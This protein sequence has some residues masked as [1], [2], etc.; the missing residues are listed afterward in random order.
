VPHYPQVNRL[1]GTFDAPT[2][3]AAVYNSRRGGREVETEGVMSGHN[4][5]STIKH[6]KGKADA[7]RGKIFTK[8]I[9]ELTTAAKEGGGDPDGNPRLRSAIAAAKAANMPGDTLKKAIQRGTGELPGVAYEEVM[10]EG[11]GPGGVAVMLQVLTDN[12][13]R[14]TAEIRHLFGK[15]GGNLGESG[16]VAYLF[17]KQGYLIVPK[18]SGSEDA[19]MEAALEAGA[20]DFFAEDPELYEIYTAPE[21][22]HKVKHALEAKGL[23]VEQ[24]KVEMVPS[25]QI[26]LEDKRAEQMVRLMEAFEDHDD[27]QNVWANFDIDV[28]LLEVS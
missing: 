4:K 26:R 24:A 1:A 15:H 13:N 19:A 9:R 18:S 27:V 25:A 23:V 14:T 8:I 5:W 2:S 3:E 7:K 6:K 16:C 17:K 10:Y 20:E 22:L 21:D 11:Y 28:K 12:R